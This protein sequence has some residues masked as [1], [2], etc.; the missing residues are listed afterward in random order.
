MVVYSCS[1]TLFL[2]YSINII[3]IGGGKAAK[4]LLEIFIGDKEVKIVGMIDVTKKQ[5]VWSVPESLES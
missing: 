4:D 3:L 2:E 5:L 1:Q